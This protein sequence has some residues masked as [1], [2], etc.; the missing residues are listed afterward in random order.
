M[1]SA[2]TFR[3]RI[4]RHISRFAYSPRT[5]WLLA[6]IVLLGFAPRLV[7]AQPIDSI[8][9]GATDIWSNSGQW[10]TADFPNN[11]NGGQDYNAIVNGGN[12]TMDVD[13]VIE[14]LTLTAGTINGGGFN[15][16]MNALLAPRF[17]LEKPWHRAQSVSP[18][19]SSQECPGSSDRV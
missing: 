19:E 15:L 5:I 13:A 16:T 17:A 12:V 4:A 8:W 2:T 3:Y 9:S 6:V 18:L 1:I 14:A 11:G 7:F 10:S